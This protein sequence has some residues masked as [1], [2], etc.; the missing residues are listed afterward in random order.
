MGMGGGGYP[1]QH[2]PLASE[3][4]VHLPCWGLK[5]VENGPKGTEAV[6]FKSR[7]DGQ[8]YKP[9][10]RGPGTSWNVVFIVWLV[11]K[12]LQFSPITLIR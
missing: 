7:R 1:P 2:L 12:T 6:A 10:S 4:V 9:L 8:K 3:G 11:S 5:G